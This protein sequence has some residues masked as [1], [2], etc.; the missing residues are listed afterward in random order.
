MM[1][2]MLGGSEWLR[3]MVVRRIGIRNSRKACIRTVVPWF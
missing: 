1:M 2:V 3:K